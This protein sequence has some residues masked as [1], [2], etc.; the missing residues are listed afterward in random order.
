MFDDIFLESQYIGFGS[1]LWRPSKSYKDYNFYC[2]FKGTPVDKVSKKAM[3]TT[4]LASG[5]V[6]YEGGPYGTNA[7]AVDSKGLFGCGAFI[8]KNGKSNDISD[9]YWVKIDTDTPSTNEFQA[10]A[11]RGRVQIYPQTTEGT[12]YTISFYAYVEEGGTL[13]NYAINHYNSESGNET[14]ITLTEER[15]RYSVTVL[16]RTGNGS[17]SM[18][19]IDTNT[20]DWSKVYIDTINITEGEILYPPVVNDSIIALA[21]PENYS[22][23]D[24][25]YKFPINRDPDLDNADD[26]D[27]VA[28]GEELIGDVD[29]NDPG[30]WI[31]NSAEI[32]NGTAIIT[33]SGAIV[34]NFETTNV[35]NGRFY[36]FNYTVDS[37]TATGDLYA[38]YLGFTES[39]VIPTSIGQ[40]KIR[41]LCIDDTHQLVRLTGQMGSIGD[42]V[43]SSL[44]VK[45]I[46]PAQSFLS[47][48]Q[49]LINALDGVADGDELVAN[50]DPNV[51]SVVDENNY[52]EYNP[53]TGIG[54]IVSDGTWIKMGWNVLSG[55]YY[56]LVYEELE[57]NGGSISITNETISV[58]VPLTDGSET[59]RFIN[60]GTSENFILGRTAGGCDVTFRVSVKEI[61]P[62]QGKIFVEGWRPMFSYDQM[63][64]NENQNI[65]K[66]DSDASSS[67]RMLY[68]RN[69]STDEGRITCYDRINFATVNGFNFQADTL[70]DITLQYGPHPSYGDA[71]RMQLTV[72]DGTTT[73]YNLAIFDG[74]WNPDGFLSFFWNNEY[75]Q[76]IKHLSI[77][78]E[79]GW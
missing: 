61:S 16:G 52:A 29:F 25:G 74:S 6:S 69:D 10:T 5:R 4:G 51:A 13:D 59:V 78:K 17:I 2:D 65:F 70:Y 20:S 40:H 41:L 55:G 72:T 56:E 54:R 12:K 63:A 49:N 71:L 46:S 57:N 31:V 62:A 35:V 34:H 67:S 30:E 44:S 7:P 47:C 8:V 18:G 3:Q 45:E 33:N 77:A 36:E 39:T 79:P 21:I 75:P 32:T 19:F 28:D 22:D 9:D 24:Q 64:G 50:N 68:V 27:V 37:K 43:L 1:G 76:Y 60:N 15:T 42:F 48:K 58:G 11:N 38:S 23:A 14:A 26:W 66:V 53:T 73:W